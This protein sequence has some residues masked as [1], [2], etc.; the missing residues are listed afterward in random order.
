MLCDVCKSES[1]CVF[2][3][4]IVD[5]KMQKVNLCESCSRERGVTD[6]TAFALADLL[7]GLGAAQDV[8]Q[9]AGRGQKCGTCGF[10]QAEFKKTGRLGCSACY[11]TFTEG[12]TSLLSS[13]HKG[14]SHS[15]KVPE[16]Q[17]R[18]V[19]KEKALKELHVQLRQA[20]KSENYEDA[21]TL[22]DR[23]RQLEVEA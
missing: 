5:G 21:A 14:S 8:E 10:T 2:L 23:I 6:P 12:I 11:A 7:Q 18:F 9:L 15:G 22:R 17:A 4:Q 16:R 3:T 1:A 13:M 19:E 20:V